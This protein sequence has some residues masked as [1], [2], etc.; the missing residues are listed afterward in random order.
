MLLVILGLPS[1]AQPKIVHVNAHAHNDYVHR[2]PL[3]EAL[4]NGFISVEADVHLVNGK[5]RVAHTLATTHSP[6]LS[7][8]YLQP[9]DSL[10]A[11]NKGRIYHEVPSPFYLMI[12]LKTNGESTYRALKE[13]LAHYPRLLCHSGTCAIK[14]FLSGKRPE[15]IMLKEPTS[16][17][18]IDGRPDDVGKGYSS[19]I[20][21]V[22]SDTYKKW[23]DW[24]GNSLPSEN[25]LQRIKALALRVHA[26]GKKLRLYAIPDKELVW[27][28]LLKAGVDLINTDHLQEL[29]IFLR[30]KG[31]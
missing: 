11:A 23:S 30:K 26:E 15:E 21:P 20:M 27:E 4:E 9:L 17:I 5:I 3:K 28:E 22:I 7:T 19:Q 25:D 6:E 12:D 16:G 29:N 1:F 2:R 8:L 31:L 24:K 18:S 10:L 13:L 14:I